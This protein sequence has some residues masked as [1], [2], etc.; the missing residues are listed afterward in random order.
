MKSMVVDPYE[1]AELCRQLAL[2]DGVHCGDYFARLTFT[3]D[4][5]ECDCE[6]ANALVAELNGV[7]DG[8]E[9]YV[10]SGGLVDFDYYVTADLRPT[11]RAIASRYADRHGATLIFWAVGES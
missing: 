4:V 3:L 9:V 10:A 8:V 7:D 6:T 11:F 1:G 2:Y 5:S